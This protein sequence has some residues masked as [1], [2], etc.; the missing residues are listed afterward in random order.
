MSFLYTPTEPDKAEEHP[1]P[2][3]PQVTPAGMDSGELRSTWDSDTE[4]EATRPRE[5]LKHLFLSMMAGESSSPKARSPDVG[6]RSSGKSLL[7]S[8]KVVARKWH[9]HK[10]GK[11]RRYT[12]K[13]I[14]MYGDGSGMI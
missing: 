3:A 10:E 11:L 8:A 14:R 4:D 1:G 13:E 9:D 6:S 5:S 2:H 12:R 7:A